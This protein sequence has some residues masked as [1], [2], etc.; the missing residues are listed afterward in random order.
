MVRRALVMICWVLH[1]GLLVA[2]ADA[3]E[4]LTPK[5][6]ESDTI[7]AATHDPRQAHHEVPDE[8][9]S[10]PPTMKQAPVKA[11]PAHV[12]R[13][14]F[15]SYQVNVAA[16]GSNILRDA[17]NE[18]SIAV[19]PANP[20]RMVIGWR[21]FDRI[22]SS[23]RQAG[24]GFSSDGGRSWSFPG[25][26]EPGVFRSDPVLGV[27]AEG[28]FYYHSLRASGESMYCDVFLSEDGGRTWGS[29][30]PAFGG[31]K[32]WLAIDRTGNMGHGNF[33]AVWTTAEGGCCERRVFT[34]SVDGGQ[35]F[36]EPI[37]LQPV[38]IWGSMALAR[39][40][41]LYIAGNEE[42]DT[43][44]FVVLRST[45]ARNPGIWPPTFNAFA[46]DLGGTQGSGLNPNPHGLLG[47]VWVAT[48]T[49][50]SITGGNVYLLCS[51][52]PPGADPM[53]VHFVR[54]EDRG[55]TWSEPIRIHADDRNAWQWMGT[56]SVAPNGR[57][58]VIWV[59][60]LAGARSN[61]GELYYASSDDGGYTWSIAVPISPAFDSH[62]GWPQQN[63]I[64][65]YYHM[66]SDN[67]GADL[68]YAATFNNE[69]DVYY[70]RIGD[71][72]CNLNRIADSLDL[73][74]ETSTDC[75]WNAIPDECEIAGGSAPDA[76]LDGAIDSCIPIVDTPRQPGGRRT[77]PTEP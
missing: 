8:R 7:S 49:S 47:Q 73:A 36:E 55:E 42:Y 19:D 69:Q 27:D 30:L 1:G 41:E 59:E 63:K 58:D 26:I 10:A 52:N 20:N 13:D 18:P 43:G 60:S 68:A 23:F 4:A 67:L 3:Q 62:L 28:R 16:D 53:D 2:G 46:V 25:K 61:N 17:A 77:T 31:D 21:Q 74:A 32:Q 72:D 40:G 65:D 75:N 39:S 6:H 22:T 56:M 44:S 5:P 29:R 71:R 37:E 38:P 9:Y 34:R 35:T 57:I 15:V 50:R 54:S 45:N 24:W 70:L 48:D 64:G 76:N 66:V 14:G 51:V 12:E 11:A 33:Y